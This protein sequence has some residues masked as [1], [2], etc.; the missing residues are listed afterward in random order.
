MPFSN[1]EKRDMIRVYYC[2]HRYATT[3]SERYL[4]MYPERP[5]RTIFLTLDRNLAEHGSFSK[6]RNSYNPHGNVE[7][8]QR[9]ILEMVNVRLP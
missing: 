5:H 8:D 2:S 3:A 9:Y 6:P 1:K 7:N 4:E